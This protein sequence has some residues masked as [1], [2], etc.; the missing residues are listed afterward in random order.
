MLVE[1]IK[2]HSLGPT[3]AGLAPSLSTRTW[4]PTPPRTPLRARTHAHT[5]VHTHAHTCLRTVQ[6]TGGR[7]A[8]EGQRAEFH[9]GFCYLCSGTSGRPSTPLPPPGWP[10]FVL[11]LLRTLLLLPILGRA[12]P[13]VR[14]VL[15]S[16]C[17]SR[18]SCHSSIK[19][20]LLVT[21][22]HHSAALRL[23]VVFLSHLFGL[24]FGLPGW[25]R[26]LR[27][28]PRRLKRVP[29]ATGWQPPLTQRRVGV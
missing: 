20:H 21:S 15:A 11:L 16:A 10:L 28:L 19:M 13:Q 9:S 6:G 22:P 4:A 12:N 3:F 2:E 5:P 26:L 18:I 1:L 23:D 7:R 14:H 27:Q 29:V 25:R 8:R 17:L 24:S